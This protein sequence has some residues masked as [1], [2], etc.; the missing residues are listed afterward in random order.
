MVAGFLVGALTGLIG[1]GGGFLIVP[2]LVT[3]AGL[4]MHVAIGTSLLLIAANSFAGLAGYTSHV[5]IDGHL[6]ALVALAAAVGSVGGAAFAAR[7]PAA[8]L[9]QGFA[10]FVL[11][12]AATMLLQR[13]PAEIALPIVG[14]ACIGLSASLVWLFSG[15]IAGVSGILAGLLR[16]R[17][18]SFP[19]R[20][21]FVTGLVA[22]GLVLRAQLPQ[23]LEITTHH[24]LA[25]FAVAGALVGFGTRLGNGCT[26]GHGVCGISRG[27]SRSLAA[28]ATFMLTAMVVVYIT[29]HVLGGA[30]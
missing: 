28:T 15:D 18:A 27:A 14:G 9:R 24:P 10:L 26:S 8:L 19:R 12:A 11:L 20:V 17:D 21:A 22:G 16:P 6:A 23:A 13:V 25:L 7:L 1:A 4:A 2:A 30:P 5:A 29:N 3:F